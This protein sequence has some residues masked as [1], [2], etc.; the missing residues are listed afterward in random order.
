MVLSPD[1]WGWHSFAHA[2]THK[3]PLYSDVYAESSLPA[4]QTDCMVPDDGYDPP[5]RDYRSRALPLS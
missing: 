5:S 1:S 2:F 4:A 3:N